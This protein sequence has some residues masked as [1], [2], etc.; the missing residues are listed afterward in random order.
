VLFSV[1][2]NGHGGVIEHDEVVYHDKPDPKP[3]PEPAPKP[4][5]EC[6]NRTINISLHFH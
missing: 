2:V 1:I 3:D 6:C 4:E 5:P